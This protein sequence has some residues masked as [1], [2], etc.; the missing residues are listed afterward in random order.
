MNKLRIWC[1]LTG[2]LLLLSACSKEQG[3][4]PDVPPP[5]PVTWKQPFEITF[6][7]DTVTYFRSHPVTIRWVLYD[8]TLATLDLY[9]RSLDED[10]W[11]KESRI[12]AAT[13]SFTFQPNRFSAKKYRFALSTTDGSYWDST[14]VV[15]LDRVPLMLVE[16]EAG[17]LRLKTDTNRFTW[18]IMDDAIAFIELRWS[19]A[20][21]GAWT[22]GWTKQASVSTFVW[23]N[24]PFSTGS[25]DFEI[26]GH[27]DASSGGGVT[28]WTSVRGVGYGEFSLTAPPAGS[29]FRR[30]LKAQISSTVI[31][32]PGFG[33]AAETVYEVS[34]DGGTTWS[35]TS[36]DWTILQPAST[37]ASVRMRHEI[38]GRVTA[39]GP[40]IIED[41]SSEYF[42]LSPGKV[43]RY[44]V[45]RVDETRYSRDTTS[46][47]WHTITV[48]RERAGIGRTEYECSIAIETPDG[49]RSTSPGLLWRQH[50]GQ[51]MIG[52]YFE[53]FKNVNLP[54]IHDISVDVLTTRILH[55][56]P[57][58]IPISSTSYETHRGKGIVSKTNTTAVSRMPPQGYGTHYILLE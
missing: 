41:K 53:P 16:P 2:L 17:Q 9:Y 5:P 43:F 50:D 4:E 56:T 6:P 19:P 45:Y 32:P 14:S 36:S 39:S 7:K 23:E 58:E 52:G 1:M 10:F 55:G 20:G 35:A 48:L 47:A 51:Q 46:K 24:P 42:S 25:M 13:R 34:T 15:S 28:E 30:F 22:N 38:M 40:Y 26:R 11:T 8:S 57:G 54:G 27:Y 33:T 31:V 18:I 37:N 44:Y 49:S 12:S 29:V 21:T 3:T